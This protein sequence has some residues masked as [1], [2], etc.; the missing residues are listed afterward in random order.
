MPGTVI[1]IEDAA[2]YKTG[3]ILAFKELIFSWW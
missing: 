3:K 2:E 1:R